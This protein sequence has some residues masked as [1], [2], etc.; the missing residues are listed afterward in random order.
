MNHCVIV[1]YSGKTFGKT[2]AYNNLQ[3]RQFI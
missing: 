1:L 2:V 3:D